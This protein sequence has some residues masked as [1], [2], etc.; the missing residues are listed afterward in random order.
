MRMMRI[1]LSVI[2]GRINLRLLCSAPPEM[3]HM[4][5]RCL[6]AS[7][8]ADIDAHRRKSAVHRA[9]AICM[10]RPV[11]HAPHHPP[12]VPNECSAWSSSITGSFGECTGS[13]RSSDQTF[14]NSRIYI[15]HTTG[16]WSSLSLWQFCVPVR[17]GANAVSCAAGVTHGRIHS[18]AT[19][20]VRAM[21]R[22]STAAAV[23]F[24]MR[25]RHTQR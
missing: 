21:R 7:A 19:L 1:Q 16:S 6:P 20:R 22:R 8:M 13:P 5:G 15:I 11:R 24:I 3:P 12:T 23:R 10:H 4:S 14:S 18:P 25:R 17:C 2:Y 9:A